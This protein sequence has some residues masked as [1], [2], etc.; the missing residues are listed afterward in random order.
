M[1]TTNNLKPTAAFTVM[2]TASLFLTAGT[3][4]VAAQAL[5]EFEFNEGTSNT[6]ADKSGALVGQLSGGTTPWGTKILEP[7]DMPVVT[8][9]SPSGQ[10]EDKSVAFNGLGYLAVDDRKNPILAVAKSPLTIE[11]W[12]NSGTPGVAIFMS[13]GTWGWGGPD[14][15]YAFRGESDG[16][17]SFQLRG[18]ATINSGL[19]VPVDQQWHHLAAVYEPGVGV[20][21]FIDGL[22]QTNFV[23]EAQSMVAPL[24]NFLR[25]G[26]AFSGGGVPTGSIDRFRIHKALLTAAQLDSDAANPKPP[27]ATTLVA[28][29]F[30]Q[31]QPP[32]TNAAPAV[33]PA[34]N[35]IDLLSYAP[36]F[37]ADSPSGTAGDFSLSFRTVER[38]GVGMRVLIEDPSG[39]SSVIDGDLTVQLWVKIGEMTGPAIPLCVGDGSGYYLQIGTD[40]KLQIVF[41]GKGA[42]G[43]QKAEIPNDGGWHHI[44]AVHVQ[45]LEV[46]FYVDG[47]LK[48]TQPYAGGVGLPDKAAFVLG[49]HFNTVCPLDGLMDRLKLST[50]KAV[51][52]DELDWRPIPGVEPQPPQITFAPAV[53][54]SWPPTLAEFVMQSAPR[55]QDPGA[56][57]I[58]P[59]KPKTEAGVFKLFL[60]VSQ[61]QEFFRLS[62]P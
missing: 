57:S 23:A 53:V 36:S 43:S 30:D 35:C 3:N 2:V 51:P 59:T 44:A 12:Y 40:R 27:L 39:Q 52:A 24:S 25:I 48:D 6:I 22:T 49:S 20:T 15:G 56:W 61:K 7:A 16:T 46:R 8:D 10:P 29:S 47:I 4:W 28:Y 9:S 32:F 34:V 13:Y 11:C 14:S 21:F 58:V 33:R 54:L 42:A 18:V 26:A 62:T 31:A 60:P 5:T 45:G 19:A 37:V 55:L 17:L 1:K 50:Y 38:A 41:P